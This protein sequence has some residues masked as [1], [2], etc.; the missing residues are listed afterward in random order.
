MSS[1]PT[2]TVLHAVDPLKPEEQELSIAKPATFSLDKF[3]SKRSPT[4]AGVKTLLPGLPI[5]SISQAK[6]FVRLHPDEENYW[7]PELCFVN[8]PIPGQRQDRVH[9]IDEEIAMRHLHASRIHRHRL[10]LATKPHNSFFFCIVPTTNLGNVWN[11]TN[12]KACLMAKEQWIEANSRR[13]EGTDA[14]G[15]ALKFARNA[16][17]FAE[18]DWPT[19]T[20]DELLAETFAGRMIETDDHP[21][22]L[23][24]VGDKTPLA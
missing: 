21:A 8:V 3:K 13:A 6:D 4:I 17:A 2:K 1:E 23:R 14:E 9:L 5:H 22:L 24:L 19:Q 7:T 11:E 20:R 15:Y 10:A 12:L 16:E 18:P